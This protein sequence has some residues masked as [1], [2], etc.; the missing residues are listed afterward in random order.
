MNERQLKAL[1]GAKTWN[2]VLLV[3]TAIGVVLSL[4]GLPSTLNPIREN[5]ELLGAAGLE[6]YEMINTPFYK[7]YTILSIV[8]SIILLVL[9]IKA[10]ITIKKENVPSDFPYFLN[11]GAQLIGLIVSFFTG[12]QTFILTIILTVISCILP[13]LALINLSKVE[14]NK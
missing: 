6:M 12:S 1:K 9:Y 3:F 7:G 11:I 13:T 5:Y 4:I 10:H 2:M 8:I 14:S